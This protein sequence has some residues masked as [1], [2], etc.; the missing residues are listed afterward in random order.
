[1]F[2]NKKSDKFSLF[3]LCL[4]LFAVFNPLYVILFLTLLERF[5]RFPKAVGYLF[6]LA[7]SLTFINRDIGN[8]WTSGDSYAADDVINYLEYYR[9]IFDFQL[10]SGLG[11]SLLGG[12]EPLWFILAGLVSILTN[13][14]EF[15]LVVVSV[16]VPVIIL[17]GVFNNVS[18]DF[19]FNTA[20]FIGV[21]PEINHVIYHLWRYSLS[22]VLVL[23]LIIT[24]LHRRKVNYQYFSTSLLAH[25]SSVPSIFIFLYAAAFK[26]GSGVR[27]VRSKVLLIL[28]F[29]IFNFCCIYLGFTFLDYIEYDKFVFYVKT[30]EIITLFSFNNRHFLYMILAS[31]I[32]VISVNRI[33]ILFSLVG[34]VL[35]SIPFFIS[36]SLVYERVLLLIMPIVI[37]L[38][39]YEIRYNSKVKLFL[40]MP[41]FLVTI[42]LWENVEGKLFYNYM[43]NGHNFN[44]WNGIFYNLVDLFYLV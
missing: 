32:L 28:S 12:G 15:F 24:Y 37:V 10:L 42:T 29:L 39:L 43:S 17:Q 23:S 16:T 21:Y 38:F 35:L 20:F 40:L 41:L 44:L 3:A 33:S 18:R 30:D 5:I 9:H 36:L 25:V 27:G 31:M 2:D 6:A 1:M 19:L 7:F 11:L 34:V 8:S 4:V 13:S 14:N 26:K 22:L